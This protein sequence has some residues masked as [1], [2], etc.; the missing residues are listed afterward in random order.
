MLCTYHIQTTYSTICMYFTG[1]CVLS[2]VDAII[3]YN[4]Q[5]GVF[6]CAGGGLVPATLESPEFNI[7]GADLDRLRSEIAASIRTTL[8]KDVRHHVTEHV[9]KVRELGLE[10]SILVLVSIVGKSVDAIAKLKSHH[11]ESRAG[12]VQDPSVYIPPWLHS[13]PHGS[14]GR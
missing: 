4:I 12:S 6:C 13:H 10:Q 9:D 8:S 11:I 5:C 3:D 14:A 7:T 1:Y 2:E